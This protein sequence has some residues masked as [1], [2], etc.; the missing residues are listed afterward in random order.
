MAKKYWW[1]KVPNPDAVIASASRPVSDERIRYTT[2]IKHAGMFRDEPEIIRAFMDTKVPLALAMRAF[3]PYQSAKTKSLEA[4]MGGAGYSSNTLQ[5]NVASSVQSR[6][7]AAEQ[8]EQAKDSKRG[9]WD[10]VLPALGNAASVAGKAFSFPGGKLMQGLNAAAEGAILPAKVGYAQD[11]N[12]D[13]GLDYLQQKLYDLPVI[14]DIVKPLAI[15]PTNAL[16]LVSNYGE[17]LYRLATGDLSQT[18]QRDI[19]GAG[20]NPNSFSS[21]YSYYFSDLGE[22][23]V[24]VSDADVAW[25]KGLSQFNPADVDAAREVVTS[26]ALDDLTRSGPSLSPM[27]QDFMQRTRTDR[28]AQSLLEAMTDTSQTSFGGRLIRNAAPDAEPGDWWGPGSTS[29]A[30]AA[31]TADVISTW[32]LGPEVLAAKGYT[33][34]RNAKYLVR[35]GTAETFDTIAAMAKTTDEAFK[36][37]GKVAVRLRQGMHTAEDIVLALN[38]K[39]PGGVAEAGRL[40][41][42]WSR[43]YPGYESTLDVLVAQRAGKM[44]PMRIREGREQLDDAAAAAKHKGDTHEYVVDQRGDGQPFWRFTRDDGTKLSDEEMALEQG[45][46]ADDLADFIHAEA[47]GSGRPINGSR[48]LLPGQLSIN[49]KLRDVFTPVMEAMSRRDGSLMKQLR[50][51]ATKNVDLN[52]PIAVDEAGRW[53][54]LVSRDAANWYQDNYTYGISHFMARAWRNLERTFSGKVI[55]PSDPRSVKTFQ[56]LTS[57]FMPKRQSQMMVA[58]YAA[59]SPAERLAMVSKTAEALANVMNLRNTPGGQHMMNQLSKGLIPIDDDA[60][61]A[62]KVGSNEQYTAP[63]DNHIKVGDQKIAAAVHT[64]QLSEGV[65][66]PDYRLARHLQSRNIVLDGVTS[67]GDG[68]TVN[69][70]IQVWKTSKT[71]TGANLVRQL[72]ESTGFNAWLY[73]EVLPKYIKARQTIKPAIIAGRV[74]KRELQRLSMNINEMTPADLDLLELA[75]RS[76][77]E[78][79]LATVTTLLAK[80]GF[81]PAHAEVLARLGQG[82]DIRDFMANLKFDGPF[83]PKYL[84]MM[85]AWDTKRRIRAQRLA[86][87]NGSITDTPFDDV[88]DNDTIVAMTQAS[89]SHLTDAAESGAFSRTDNMLNQNRQMVISGTTQGLSH[90]PLALDNGHT[91]QTADITPTLWQS[92]LGPRQ[93][94]EIDNIVMRLIAQRTLVKKALEKKLPEGG[95]LPDV[96]A[97]AAAQLR[98]LALQHNIDPKRMT[99]PDDLMAYLLAEHEWGTKMRNQAMAMHYLPDGQFGATTQADMAISAQAN[100]MRGTNDLVRTMGGVIERDTNGRIVRMDFADEADPL[101]RKIAHDDKIG[102]EDLVGLPEQTRPEGLVRPMYAPIIPTGAG[103]QRKFANTASRLYDFMVATPLRN[104]ML[105]PMFIAQKRVAYGHLTPMLEALV[106]RGHTPGQAAYALESL[107]NRRARN[108]VFKT[109]D[110]PSEKMIMAEMGEKWFMFVRAQLDF[111]RRFGEA[112]AAN[113]AG[114]ARASI[115]LHAGQHSGSIAAQPYQDE[116]GNTAQKLTF[117]YPGSPQAQ[118]VLA[119]AFVALGF[120]PEEMLRIPQFDGFKSQVDWINPSLAN[121]TSF[122]LNPVFGLAVEGAEVLWPGATVDLERIKRGFVYGGQDFEGTEKMVS[123]RNM[124]PSFFSRWVPL[125]TEDDADGQLQSAE[126]SALMYSELT[127]KS[128]DAGAS[129]AERARFMDSIKATATNILIARA[130]F[131]VFAPAAPQIED[132]QIIEKDALARAQGLTNLRG[133]FFAIRNEMA[134][135]YPEDFSRAN[136]ESILEFAKRYPGEL[137]ANPRAFSVGSTKVS[138]DV[139]DAYVPYTIEATRWLQQ[140]K[141]FVEANPTVA[142]AMMPKTTAD[143]DFSNEAY[144]LQLKADLRTHKDLEQ[145]YIDVTLSD[146]ISQFYDTRSKYFAAANSD[147]MLSSSIHAKRDKWEDMWKRTHPL[148]VQ[149][150]NRRAN[151]DFVHAQV[152][153]S[154]DRILDGTD[155][156]PPEM[157]Q[158]APQVREMYEDYAGY[159]ERYFAVS[160]YNNAGRSDANK[161]YQQAGDRKWIGTPMAGLWDLMRVNEGR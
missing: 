66:L 144:K 39:T 8:A 62:V 67:L 82:V 29:R 90:R 114:L 88:L 153:P 80:N 52:G 31:A 128:P 19:R 154:L 134:K 22:K 118:R 156:L 61:N 89:I 116:N 25:L 34:W 23:R 105:L 65:K 124:V 93:G 126:R 130:I 47:Y 10:F 48:L 161:D 21:R 28:G 122:S 3:Q 139:E 127:G 56:E 63:I 68:A 121:P 123:W 35:T 64:W 70:A 54:T 145:F 72:L 120:Y 138:A 136:S 91:W 49:G 75:R 45:K 107:A 135:R 132:P 73:P 9:F 104:L 86:E 71:A 98:D 113:P 84:A 117:T 27:A 50:E 2:A 112:T 36:P 149:E 17:G 43:R 96:D 51:T 83:R 137:I 115:L 142:L 147:P 111:L 13:K 99:N 60:I 102:L 32:T 160:Y 100:A 81:D 151:P 4:M 69:A 24:P 158:Y 58:Q 87:K 92:Q 74:E 157:K 143:G 152:A 41:Q 44:G 148:A 110:N 16:G 129:P 55:I 7:E 15:V 40:R 85:H 155:P 119:D 106:D 78:A 46:V 125:M 5:R 101:L 33:T 95:E 141:A 150:M 11:N 57:S 6:E 12:F 133:E 109:S 103:W 30:I 77:P 97:I 53:S 94:D 146:D 159:R 26:G 18:Q 79:Y 38:T 108:L 140:N 76:E 59:G 14:G 1:Q 20:G 42:S 131:G 37:Q